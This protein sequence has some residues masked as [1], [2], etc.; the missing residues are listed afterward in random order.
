MQTPPPAKELPHERDAPSPLPEDHL[1]D[2]GAY[3]REG[4]PPGEGLQ[5]LA[6]RRPRVGLGGNRHA[7]RARGQLGRL[8]T[9]PETLEL[10]DSSGA[11]VHV[12]ET[13]AA[14]ALYNRLAESEA[15]GGLFHSTC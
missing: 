9:C 4:P 8:H 2:L 14:V 3:R 11:T 13:S 15:V 7:P 1:P 12:E 6:G 10:L 5:A